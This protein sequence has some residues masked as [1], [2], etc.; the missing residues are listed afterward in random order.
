[1][2][3]ILNNS[4]RTSAVGRFK[5]RTSQWSGASVATSSASCSSSFYRQGSTYSNGSSPEQSPNSSRRGSINA[6][7]WG[8]ELP[9][10]ED[11]WGFF[12]DCDNSP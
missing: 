12:V 5:R 8:A 4:L 3:G 9:M 11:S 2:P 7:L 10:S 1:M 6:S